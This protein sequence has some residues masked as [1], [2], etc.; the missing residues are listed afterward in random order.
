[1][2]VYQSWCGGVFWDIFTVGI[3]PLVGTALES[4]IDF[5]KSMDASE[6]ESPK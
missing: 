5:L 1:M 3:L 4:V 6:N 2:D